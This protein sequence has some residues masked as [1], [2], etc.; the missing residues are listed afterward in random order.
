M[1]EA[2]KQAIAEYRK[3]HPEMGEDTLKVELPK[4]SEAGGSEGQRQ[5][6]HLPPRYEPINPL[7]PVQVPE[8]NRYRQRLAAARARVLEAQLPRPQQNAPQLGTAMADHRRAEVQQAQRQPVEKTGQ[9][10]E[11]NLAHR[12]DH[13]GRFV[14]N[15]SRNPRPAALPDNTVNPTQRP[16]GNR[17][18]GVRMNPAG[19]KQEDRWRV[20]VDP[21][22]GA[23]L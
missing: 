16:R 2:Q 13:T 11:G 10:Q 17:T 20:A 5:Q 9:P 8:L 18:N 14:G 4:T 23:V 15:N 7:H 1:E 3:E 19:R 12:R 22:D 6:A 21:G